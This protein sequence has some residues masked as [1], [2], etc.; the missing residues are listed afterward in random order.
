MDNTVAEFI[1]ARHI[2][3]IQKLYILL[4]LYQHP[5]LT[6]TSQELSDRLFIGYLPL[7]EEILNEL[8]QADLVDYVESHYQLCDN[9]QIRLSLQALVETFEN[10]VTR[11]EIIEQVSDVPDC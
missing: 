1:R 4:V 5:E 6:K 7:V 9:P 10:P 3:S 11:Q 2:D 8:Q